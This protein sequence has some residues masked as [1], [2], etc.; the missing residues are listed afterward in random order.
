MNEIVYTKLIR[1]VITV[2]LQMR[3]RLSIWYERCYEQNQV[4]D[5]K[6]KQYYSIHCFGM[7]LKNFNFSKYG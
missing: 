6:L 5:L 2:L 7:P 1:V 4:N 3:K